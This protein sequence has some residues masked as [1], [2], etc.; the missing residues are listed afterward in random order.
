MELEG[1]SA[2]EIA[3][4]LGMTPGAVGNILSKAHRQRTEQTAKA[5]DLHRAILFERAEMIIEK[6][7]PIALDDDLFER[8]ARGEPVSAASVNQAMR[9]ALIALSQQQKSELLAEGEKKRYERRR[10][11][12]ERFEA[13]ADRLSG[14][15]RSLPSGVQK[16]AITRRREL[17]HCPERRCAT[18]MC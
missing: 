8:I 10:Q 12:R 9:S 1:C 3:A 17:S 2:P 13:T 6:F 7:A 14:E 18:G 11:E 15:L 16:T 4:R 5:I